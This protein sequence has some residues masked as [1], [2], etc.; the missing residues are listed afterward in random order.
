MPT[1][2]SLLLATKPRSSWF[3]GYLQQVKI[4]L[5]YGTFQQWS[6]A[7]ARV[8]VYTRLGL[9]V[10]YRVIKHISVMKFRK[11]YRIAY[12]FIFETTSKHEHINSIVCVFIILDRKSSLNLQRNGCIKNKKILR[13]VWFLLTEKINCETYIRHIFLILHDN[14]KFSAL[15]V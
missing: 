3:M 12:I 15:C 8:D 1:L 4:A 10:G 2:R 14:K 6:C 11:I 9:E 7:R 5:I 13:K